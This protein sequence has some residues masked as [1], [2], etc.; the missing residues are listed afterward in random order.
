M[1][2]FIAA[3]LV[4]SQLRS[5]QATIRNLLDRIAVG[6]CINGSSGDVSLYPLRIQVGEFPAPAVASAESDVQSAALISI[7][8]GRNFKVLTEKLS[9]EQYVLTQCGTTPPSTAEIEDLAPNTSAYQRKHFSIPLQR[10]AAT[11]TTS[12]AFFRRLQIQDRV[13][14]ADP[15]ASGPCWQKALSCGSQL[16]SAWGNATI[17]ERQLESLDA[18]FMD[19]GADCAQVRSRGNAV[20]FPATKDNGNLHAAEYIKFVAAFFNLEETAMQIFDS[21]VTTYTSFTSSMTSP[22]VVAWV[23]WNGYYDR[24]ELSQASYKLQLVRAA[25]GKNVNATQVAEQIGTLMAMED[26]VAGNPQAGKTYY[27]LA[28]EDKSAAA[29]ALVSALQDVDIVVDETYAPYPQAYSFATF[30]S[31]FG[32]TESS[33]QKFVSQK[34]VLRVDGTLSESDGLD[35][36]ESRVAY[37][38]WAAEGLARY[39]RGDAS[40]RRKYFRNIAANEEPEVLTAAMCAADLPSCNE[41]SFAAPID[42]AS[43]TQETELS[44]AAAAWAMLSVPLLYLNIM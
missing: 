21:T 34:Y 32:L 29:N 15:F 30:L 36:F 33:T 20:H 16:E 28:G 10:V 44:G 6:E 9:Q 31:T 26:V 41:S 39:I 38:D 7:A 11:S 19:C 24:F 42:V 18:V 23:Q 43:I 27:I 37:P 40:Q 2:V 14:Y 3:V 22:P 25:G 1:A 17:R 4:L 5:V 13:A 35:W 12:L 8:Y